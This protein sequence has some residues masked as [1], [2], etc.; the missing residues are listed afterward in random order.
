[1]HAYMECYLAVKKKKN[2]RLPPATTGMNLEGIVLSKISQRKTNA[3]DFTYS[4]A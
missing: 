4:G 3:I 2:E 1:M